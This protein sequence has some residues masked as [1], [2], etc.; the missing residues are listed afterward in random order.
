MEVIVERIEKD[1]V[2][3]ELPNGKH[4]EVPKELF[5]NVKENDVIT[6]V[7][8]KE[9]TASKKVE[10]QDIINQVFED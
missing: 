3:V 2:V 10:I 5:G 9:K 6:I 1:I 8:D 4:L 7:V